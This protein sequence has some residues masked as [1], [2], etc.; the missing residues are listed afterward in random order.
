MSTYEIFLGPRYPIKL[1]WNKQIL[2]KKHCI[3]LKWFIL[4][5]LT[6]LSSILTIFVLKSTPIVKDCSG[7][8]SSS[9]NRSSKLWIKSISI[10]TINVIMNWFNNSKLHTNLDL[11]TLLSPI[12]KTF[13][14][15][16]SLTSSIFLLRVLLARINDEIQKFTQF[17]L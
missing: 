12:I 11:P 17:V 16:N 13:N 8:N 2:S 4:P 6:W 10:N 15:V 1:E 3:L 14:V 9:M 7:S 5:S